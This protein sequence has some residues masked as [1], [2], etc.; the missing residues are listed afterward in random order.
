MIRQFSFVT[1]ALLSQSAFADTPVPQ[2]VPAQIQAN[3]HTKGSLHAPPASS[4]ET[5]SPYFYV[6]TS[7][8]EVEDFPLKKTPNFCSKTPPI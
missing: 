1:A 3:V 6:A 4:Q 2:I 7:G 5:L 8:V